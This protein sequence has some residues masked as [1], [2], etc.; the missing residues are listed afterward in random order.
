MDGSTAV[1]CETDKKMLNP[2][3]N[4]SDNRMAAGQ[5]WS[6]DAAGNVIADSRGRS[7]IYDANKQAGRSRERA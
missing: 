2:D 4:T 5:G 7:F 3:L 6:Y 1:V